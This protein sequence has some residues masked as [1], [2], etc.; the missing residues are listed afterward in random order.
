MSIYFQTKIIIY[1]LQKMLDKLKC[2]SNNNY[3][4]PAGGL[5][6]ENNLVDSSGFTRTFVY[7]DG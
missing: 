6:F 1:Y 2:M 7:I 3:E 4:S 5:S